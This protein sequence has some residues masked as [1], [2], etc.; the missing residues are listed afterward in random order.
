MLDVLLM[1]KKDANNNFFKHVKK[2][3]QKWIEQDDIIMSHNVFEK[4][5]FPVINSNTPTFFLLI[6]NFYHSLFHHYLKTSVFDLKQMFF[7]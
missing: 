4:I 5:V 6:D 3:Y 7:V 1:Q 2:N